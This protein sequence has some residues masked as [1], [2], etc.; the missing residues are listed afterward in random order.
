MQDSEV[1]VGHTAD[2]MKATLVF[3]LF[4]PVEADAMFGD[5]P[6]VFGTLEPPY[7]CLVPTHQSTQATP[8]TYAH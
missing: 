6:V 7:N 3:R 1:P 5:V 4:F 8:S 2:W